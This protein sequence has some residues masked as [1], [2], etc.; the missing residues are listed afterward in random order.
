MSGAGGVRGCARWARV[1]ALAGAAARCYLRGRVVTEGRV[2][3]RFTAVLLAFATLTAA[4]CGSPDARDVASFDRADVS[5]DGSVALSDAHDDASF[6]HPD[7]PID[8]SAASLD[9][10][11]TSLDRCPTVFDGGLCFY[12][13]YGTRCEVPCSL[14]PACRFTLAVTWGGNGYCCSSFENSYRSCECRD[15]L[16]HCSPNPTAPPDLRTIP[17]STCEFCREPDVQSVDA[18]SFNE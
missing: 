13:G 16:V 10:R 5:I 7:I 3:G 17:I 2:M 11:D 8:G 1:D 12:A 6:D 15:G 9:A 18:S 14:V 4:S